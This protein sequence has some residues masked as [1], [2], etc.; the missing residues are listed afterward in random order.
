[1]LVLARGSYTFEQPTSI[2]KTTRVG[3]PT[4]R[5]APVRL[6]NDHSTRAGQDD[7]SVASISPSFKGSGI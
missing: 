7:P 1:M 6:T 5:F 4:D 3:V 2:E